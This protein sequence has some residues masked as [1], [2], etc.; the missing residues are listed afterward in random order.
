MR[1]AGHSISEVARALGIGRSVVARRTRL[2]GGQKRSTHWRQA[3][4]VLD[5]WGHPVD[6]LVSHPPKP[7]SFYPDDL[8]D[9]KRDPFNW[10]PEELA[11]ATEEARKKLY[12]Q[13][14]RK[15]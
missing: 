14:R 1:E 2:P 13:T 12:R 9:L 11:S 15:S 5:E 6:P 3:Q 7:M 4:Q 8:P 10:T